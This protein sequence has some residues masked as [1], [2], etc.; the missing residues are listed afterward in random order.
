MFEILFCSWEVVHDRVHHVHHV[1]HSDD[2][3]EHR[4]E[5]VQASSDSSSEHG[6]IDES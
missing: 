5:Y 1:T 4:H 2:P 3:P 6:V